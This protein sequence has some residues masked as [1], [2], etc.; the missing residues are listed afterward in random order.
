MEKKG[1]PPIGN[2]FFV[3]HRIVSTVK[4]AEF[5]SDNMTYTVLRGRCFNAIFS[6]VHAPSEE[7][8]YDKKES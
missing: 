8:S 4:R 7:K 3:H 2:M 1:K 6:N 5:V